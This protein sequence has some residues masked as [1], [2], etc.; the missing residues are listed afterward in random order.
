MFQPYFIIYDGRK[1]KKLS[2]IIA[3]YQLQAL[4]SYSNAKSNWFLKEKK[5]WI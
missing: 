2:K 4:C 1:R 3:V 5:N